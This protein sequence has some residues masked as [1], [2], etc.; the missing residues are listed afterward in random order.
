M[1]VTQSTDKQLSQVA[2]WISGDTE[3]GRM[4]TDPEPHE[5]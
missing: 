1:G 2:V 5:L 4:A 3:A